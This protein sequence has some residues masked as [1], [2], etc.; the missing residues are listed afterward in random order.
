MPGSRSS[1]RS[2]RRAA[3][4][5]LV[6]LPVLL[7]F[8]FWGWKAYRSRPNGKFVILVADFDGPTPKSFR[9]SEIIVEKIRLA[10]RPYGDIE[11]RP[12]NRTITAHQGSLEATRIARE[13]N[14]DIALWG[15]YGSTA[16]TAIATV[17]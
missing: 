11:V 14:A 2:G 4:I 6:C 9:L 16:D 17:H 3:G 5:V 12:L 7:G 15:W 10:T 13:N 1:P 8:S